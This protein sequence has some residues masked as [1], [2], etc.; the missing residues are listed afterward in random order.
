MLQV[1]H[2]AREFPL[3]MVW[4]K[5]WACPRVWGGARRVSAA[6]RQM[7]APVNLSLLVGGLGGA[8]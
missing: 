5:V 3:A 8:V 2:S 6:P 4:A 1:F 7:E